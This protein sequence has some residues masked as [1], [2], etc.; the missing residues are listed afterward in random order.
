MLQAAVAKRI[1]VH[2]ASVQNWERGILTPGIRQLPAI[3]EFLGY[4]P[5]AEPTGLPAR[6]V[7]ARRRLGMTQDELAE[8]LK[9][10]S[11]TLYR[12]EMGKTKPPINK[13]D[14]IQRIVGI[15]ALRPSS[16]S[17]RSTAFRV[18]KSW[19]RPMTCTLVGPKW[20]TTLA[21]AWSRFWSK[22]SSLDATT[23][24]R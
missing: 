11:C 15:R 23:K 18:R 20:I 8:A 24:S 14:A 6:I 17:S 16:T 5:E 10:N 2:K 1:G 13:L 7:Y 9:V 22:K 3:I 12:W 4:D 19:P 21:G